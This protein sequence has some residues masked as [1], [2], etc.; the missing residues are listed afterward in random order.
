ME[1]LFVPECSTLLDDSLYQ[2]SFSR[3][4]ARFKRNPSSPFLRTFWFI[5]MVC[6]HYVRRGVRLVYIVMFSKSIVRDIVR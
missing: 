5:C 6:G 1:L 4:L 3:L 2:F